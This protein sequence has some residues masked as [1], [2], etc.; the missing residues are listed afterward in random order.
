[1]HYK[2][3]R[4]KT[5]FHLLVQTKS[6]NI[7]AN[8]DFPALSLTPYK[9]SNLAKNQVYFLV[10]LGLNKSPVYKTIKLPCIIA[11]KYKITV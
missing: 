9:T 11:K 8:H 1:M 5:L 3:T 2:I 10:K 4:F 6:Q 7:K